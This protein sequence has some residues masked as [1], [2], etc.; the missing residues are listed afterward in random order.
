MRQLYD[1]LGLLSKLRPFAILCGMTGGHCPIKFE[2]PT[3]AET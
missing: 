1:L 3:A 2:S